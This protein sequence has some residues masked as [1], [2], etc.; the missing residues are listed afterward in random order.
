MRPVD[1]STVNGQ[2]SGIGLRLERF[3]DSTGVFDLRRRWGEGRIDRA[4]L[5]GMDGELA[6]KALAGGGFSFGAEAVLILEVG[7]DTIDR[8]DTGCHGA[9]QAK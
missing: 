7:E 6:G 8:L 5:S 4:D 3:H 2:D 1:H 9:C